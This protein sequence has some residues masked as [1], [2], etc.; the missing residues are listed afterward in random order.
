MPHG[1][2]KWLDTLPL[3]HA[4]STRQCLPE[5]FLNCNHKLEIINKKKRKYVVDYIFEVARYFNLDRYDIP[6]RAIQIFDRFTF[7]LTLETNKKWTQAE[8]ALARYKNATRIVLS[9]ALDIDSANHVLSFVNRKEITTQEVVEHQERMRD[10]HEETCVVCLNLASKFSESHFIDYNDLQALLEHRRRVTA[11]Y[12]KEHELTVLDKIG[13]NLNILNAY[14]FESLLREQI[15]YTPDE[16]YS[17]VIDEYLSIIS[18]LYELQHKS[19]CVIAAIVML[20]V[21]KR[22]GAEFYCTHQPELVIACELS[23]QK[24]VEELEKDVKAVLALI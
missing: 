10:L 2:K 3:L 17:S 12:L 21:F 20:A 6:V 23:G 9:R 4:Q 1:R 5:A 8:E 22:Q 19:A 11:E 14:H 24:V 13:W 16:Y 18:P 7:Q 15:G